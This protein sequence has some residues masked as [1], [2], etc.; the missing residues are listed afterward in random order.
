MTHRPEHRQID[1]YAADVVDLGKKVAGTR[2]RLR[3]RAC[4]PDHVTTR[5]VRYTDD[6]DTVVRCAGCGKKH[7]TESLTTEQ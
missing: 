3:C 5:P 2:T 7:S 1:P 4:I 6:P